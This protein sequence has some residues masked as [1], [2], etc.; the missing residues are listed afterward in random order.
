VDPTEELCLSEMSPDDDDTPRNRHTMPLAS[1][2][3]SME[4][5]PTAVMDYACAYLPLGLNAGGEGSE[6]SLGMRSVWPY[7]SQPLDYDDRRL[8]E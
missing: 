4:S 7:R 8:L 5:C 2:M 3:P 1:M 6:S